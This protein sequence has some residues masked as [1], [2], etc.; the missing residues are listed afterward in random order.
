MSLNNWN[1]GF[2]QGISCGYDIGHR[3]GFFKGIA[4]SVIATIFAYLIIAF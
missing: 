1:E 3:N 2:K 4:L